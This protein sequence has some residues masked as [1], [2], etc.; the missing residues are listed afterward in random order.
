MDQ[1]PIVSWIQKALH[2]KANS[3]QPWL[4]AKKRH[5]SNRLLKTQLFSNFRQTGTLFF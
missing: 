4:D 5:K 3:V 2:S 1:Q